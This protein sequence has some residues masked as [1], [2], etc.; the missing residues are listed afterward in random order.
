M[1][2][3]ERLVGV[4]VC[5]V[6]PGL[7]A[8][9]GGLLRGGVSYGPGRGIGEGYLVEYLDA[10]P[11]PGT[12]LAEGS[13]VTFNIK[14]RYSL[15]RAETGRIQLQFGNQSGE[16]V[17][18]GTVAVVEIQKCKTAIANVTQQVTV[19]AGIWELVAYVFVVPDGEKHPVGEL[20]INY[21]VGS[22]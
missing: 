8:G 13:Q 2:V 9:C 21:L 14:V 4:A 5:G 19:P 18:R 7:L 12:F 22:R 6:T 11:A 15:M 16:R 17:L 3:C 20:R 1:S 10:S